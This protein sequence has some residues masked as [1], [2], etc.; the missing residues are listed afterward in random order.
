MMGVYE[1]ATSIAAVILIGDQ[2][3]CQ[4]GIQPIP[5]LLRNSSRPVTVALLGRSLG[6]GKRG[7]DLCQ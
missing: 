2:L 3:L 5:R 1:E 7:T 4:L 6:C